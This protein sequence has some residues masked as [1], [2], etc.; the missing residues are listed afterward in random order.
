MMLSGSASKGKTKYFHYYHCN[1]KCGIRFNANVTNDKFL[2][3][4]KK[5]AINPSV[6]ELYKD[7]INQEYEIAIGEG[8][9]ELS[10][11]KKQ[12]IDHQNKISK[13]RDLLLN[14]DL[15]GAD[16]KKIKMD[17]ERQVSILEGKLLDLSGKNEGIGIVLYK[18]LINVSKLPELY[19]SADSERKRQV[20]SSMFPEKLTFDGEQHR[21]LR[22]N[23]AISVFDSVKAVFEQKKD[24]KS[25]SKL[26]LRSKVTWERIELSTH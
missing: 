23:Q 13:A 20:V 11:Y 1:S 9:S 2:D 12:L 3:L 24:R 8:K 21:T 7:L 25:V 17:S 19:Q 4:L 14:G 10:S 18:A 26:D 5:H 16:Y 15:D 22:V 6:C